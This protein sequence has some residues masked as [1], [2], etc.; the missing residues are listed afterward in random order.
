[1]ISGQYSSSFNIYFLK[2]IFLRFITNL[3]DCK[4]ILGCKICVALMTSILLY[5]Y[6]GVRIKT[7]KQE[8]ILKFQYLTNTLPLVTKGS[9]AKFLGG[10]ELFKTLTN[11]KPS[12]TILYFFLFSAMFQIFLWSFKRVRGLTNDNI[13]NYLKNLRKAIGKK[14]PLNKIRIFKNF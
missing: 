4:I 5:D 11:E 3:E 12:R 1:M 9:I 14:F 13:P 10:E 2:F 7:R 6:I 8:N